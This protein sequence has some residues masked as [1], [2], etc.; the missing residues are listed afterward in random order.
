[1]QRDNILVTV[2]ST[3]ADEITNFH[4]LRLLY[5]SYHLGLS[6]ATL[7]IIYRKSVR[8]IEYW[9]SRWEQFKSVMRL[10]G[11]VNPRK[12]NQDKKDFIIKYIQSNPCSF[13]DEARGKF[14]KEYHVTI[15]LS[16]IWRII[17]AAGMTRK[18]IE[19][20]AIQICHSDII[21]F[22]NDLLSL[23]SGWHI[24]ILSFWMKLALIIAICSE[25]VDMQ[26]KVIE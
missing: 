1:M 17:H 9:I 22:F 25:S 12:F 11:G 5:G 6:K 16:T 10:T 23:P 18:V 13:L 21:R 2:S 4:L 8:A 7:S 14:I 26:S 20:R 15:S 3:Q 24:K 19:R